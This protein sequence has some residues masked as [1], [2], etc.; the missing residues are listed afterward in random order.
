M[1]EE[2]PQ[3][4]EDR[5]EAYVS[6]KSS[7]YSFFSVRKKR[8]KMK[9]NKFLKPIDSD[10]EPDDALSWVERARKIKQEKELKEM[11]ERRKRLEA[12]VLPFACTVLMYSDGSYGWV[13]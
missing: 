8:E 2:E 9:K 3:T 11:E 12:E 6:L 10:E 1:K 4:L 7:C 13:Q 5:L